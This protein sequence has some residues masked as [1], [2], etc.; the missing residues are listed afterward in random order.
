[1]YGAILGDII[2]SRF[3]FDMS[4]KVKEFNL[5][6]SASVFT[7]DSV[8][9]IAIAEALINAGKDPDEEVAKRLMIHSMKKWGRAIPHAGYGGMFGSWLQSEK[10]EPYGSFGNGSAMRVSAAGWLYDTIEMTRKVA[11]WTAEITHNHPEGIKGAES[12][13]SVIFLARQGMSKEK[14]KEYVVKEFGYNLSRTCDEIRPEYH[15]VESCQETVPEA[16]TAFLEGVSFEDVIRTAV[17]LGGDA[18]TLTD[19]AGAMAEA[20][21]GCDDFFKEQCENR[22]TEDMKQVLYKFNKAVNQG[23]FEQEKVYIK[24]TINDERKTR[25]TTID[26]LIKEVASKLTRDI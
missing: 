23:V 3:E 22:I 5:F 16:I 26:G 2:G 12:V 13:A 19:I 20:Y 8:M 4:P 18:D 9:T 1:M 7:D 17:S 24:E 21:Y 25:M 14:I 15:H 10:S 6:D 11:R